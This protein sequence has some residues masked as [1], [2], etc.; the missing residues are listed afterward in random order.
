MDIHEDIQNMYKES[1]W[2][3]HIDGQ[4][5]IDGYKFREDNRLQKLKKV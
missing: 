1:N 3:K 2:G 5:V 4:F